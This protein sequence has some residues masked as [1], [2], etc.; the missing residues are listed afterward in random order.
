MIYLPSPQTIAFFLA[1][2]DSLINRCVSVWNE[3]RILPSPGHLCLP[4][5]TCWTIGHSL[6]AD[7]SKFSIIPSISN[8]FSADT[9]HS[10]TQ[11]LPKP[12]FCLWRTNC[13]NFRKQGV[14]QVLHF[15]QTLTLLRSRGSFA[16]CWPL[17]YPCQESRLCYTQ[18]KSE[19]WWEAEMQSN[20]GDTSNTVLQVLYG[21]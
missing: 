9:I 20:V 10:I 1:D 13:V 8:D 6:L 17:S 3:V 19:L 21:I 15:C 5:H 16:L 12:S 7:V 14:S 2:A 4:L 18:G 11:G